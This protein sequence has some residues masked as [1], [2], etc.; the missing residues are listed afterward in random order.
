[1][2]PR[3]PNHDMRGEHVLKVE[4]ER[5]TNGRTNGCTR[6]DWRTDER[7]N[8]WIMDE[9]ERTNEWMMDMV[10][11]AERIITPGQKEVNEL[12]YEFLEAERKVDAFF[13]EKYSEEEFHSTCPLV[14]QTTIWEVSM[15]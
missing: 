8:E 12:D 10:D 5:R 15:C 7:T 4:A 11:E 2:S 6:T 13:D 1:M 14:A 9:N 3:G